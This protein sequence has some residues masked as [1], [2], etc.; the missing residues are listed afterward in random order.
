MFVGLNRPVHMEACTQA[1]LNT[2]NHSILST[3]GITQGDLLAMAMYALAIVPLIYKLRI[4]ALD[5]K[6]VWYADDSTLVGSCEKLRQW[7]DNVE[8]S[9]PLFGYYPNGAET[10]PI[11]KEKYVSK[12]KDLFADTEVH[13]TTDGMHHFG[14][15]LGANSFTK[16]YA[17][18]KV[19][20][21]IAEIMR[22]SAIASTQPHAAYAAFT[23][24]PSSH[25]TYISRTIPNIQELLL[26][27][28][29]AIHQH[30]I[31]AL[32]KRHVSSKIECELFAL[33]G[34]LGGMG[35]NNPTKESMY[36]FKASEHITAPLV[37]L[38]LAQETNQ[39]QRNDHQKVKHLVKRRK[40]ELLKE[41]AEEIKAQLNLKLQRSLSLA[42]EK[43]S[44]AW[45]SVLPVA[46]H[47]FLLHEGSSTMHCAYVTDEPCTTPESCN[48]GD[49]FSVDHAMIC[50]MRGIPT[51]RHNKIGDITATLLTE[52][53]HNVATEPALQQRDSETFSYR[54]ANSD[55]NA[56]LD[57]HSRGFWNRG[58]DTFFDV[59][60][61]HPNTS[62]YFT[63]I[64]TAY[65][66]HE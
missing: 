15:A 60:V 3:E 12:A 66:K 56:R 39:V 9:G 43:G 32:T 22:L 49:P 2:L 14:A 21:W 27:L 1:V 4:N 47:G 25:W 7:W 65:R 10:Y 62:N 48:C 58:Q 35:I 24:G 52:I 59:G 36:A 41:C 11:V 64:A 44:S 20:G 51:I 46:E 13:I 29:N 31:P 28:E 42:Q 34:R 63:T 54:S 26:P 6:Q 23:H 55:P 50:H 33:P 5:V 40:Q 18:S 38:I 45:L 30:F 57:I 17:S 61:F 8:C 16:A 53:C 37:A 19:E